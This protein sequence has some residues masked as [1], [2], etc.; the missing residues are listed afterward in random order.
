MVAIPKRLDELQ[1]ILAERTK[2]VFLRGGMRAQHRYGRTFHLEIL[3]HLPQIRQHC[4]WLTM[5][6]ALER[7]KWL[8]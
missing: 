6:R 5:L 7:I 8:Q 3:V 1:S 2:I 4:L